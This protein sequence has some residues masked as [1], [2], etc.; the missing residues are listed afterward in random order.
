MQHIGQ[1]CSKLSQLLL[2]MPAEHRPQLPMLETVVRVLPCWFVDAQDAQSDV[3]AAIDRLDIETVLGDAQ[4]VMA[5]LQELEDKYAIETPSRR[6]TRTLKGAYK[7]DEFAH[8]SDS[9]DDDAMDDDDDDAMDDD[10]AMGNTDSMDDD[11]EMPDH[12]PKRPYD[13]AEPTSADPVGQG[14]DVEAPGDGDSG[15][16]VHREKRARLVSA[17]PDLAG[18]DRAMTDAPDSQVTGD[19]DIDDLMAG[20]PATGFHPAA[21]HRRLTVNGLGLDLDDAREIPVS[22][23]SPAP[24]ARGV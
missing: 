21:Q 18:P 6:R 14:A 22:N 17:T 13:S 23:H 16:D 19:T 2:T 3:A 4:R 15:E 20:L 1:Y 9:D 7:S 11:T 5:E 12:P 8:D 10:A 24:C